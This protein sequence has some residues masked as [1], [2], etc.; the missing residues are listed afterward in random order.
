MI[1]YDA[2]QV[3]GLKDV[4]QN[5]A[6]A[7]THLDIDFFV[8]GAIARNMWYAH[9]GKEPSGTRDIDF[10]VFVADHDVYNEL[11][12]YLEERYEYKMS[13]DNAFGLDTPDGKRIDLL[14]F[15][16]IANNGE[17]II[18]G[19]GVTR[20]KL[21]GFN[22][23]YQ[24]GSVDTKVE[25]D[26]YKACSI[27]GIVILK[28]IAYDDRPDRRIKDIKDISRICQNYPEIETNLIWEEHNDLY[29]DNL[30]HK[31]VGL[32]VLGREMRRIIK[33]NQNLINRLNT[34]LTNAIEENSVILELMITDKNLETLDQKAHMLQCIK[35]GLNENI[36]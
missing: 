19:S 1:T 16:Q 14:P 6:T 35:R 13:V 36:V 15:G 28:L 17:V 20:I 34:I 3:E 21:D 5:I 18:R 4:L 32:I 27:A 7:C 10:G 24:Y 26:A 31:D 8:V 33:H 30:S 9:G 12:N 23:V 22:E 25:N 11:K 2:L 29:E